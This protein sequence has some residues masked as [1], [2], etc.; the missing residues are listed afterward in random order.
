MNAGYRK[1]NRLKKL[2]AFCQ[3]ARLGSVTKAAEALCASQPTVSLQIQALV[4]EVRIAPFER[5]GPQLKLTVEGEILYDLA[6]PLVQ[7]IDH[8]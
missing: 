8:L 5:R 2:R 4:R 1:Q 3:T 7:G 6:Q